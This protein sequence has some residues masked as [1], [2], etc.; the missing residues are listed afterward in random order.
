MAPR[1]AVDF[2]L[3]RNRTWVP[4]DA[5]VMANLGGWQSRCRPLAV[6]VLVT[7]LGGCG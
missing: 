1:T 3:A 7:D 4:P 6:E 2:C 5:C